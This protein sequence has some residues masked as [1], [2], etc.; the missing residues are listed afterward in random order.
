MEICTSVDEWL[1]SAPNI[2]VNLSHPVSCT[3]PKIPPAHTLKLV[4]P[5]GANDS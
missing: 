2:L 5:L 1:V 3:S 4:V